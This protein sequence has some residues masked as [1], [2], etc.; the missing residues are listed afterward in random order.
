M[1]KKLILE[2]KCLGLKVVFFLWSEIQIHEFKRLGLGIEQGFL[3]WVAGDTM[4]MKLF[5][6][7]LTES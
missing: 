5:L 7:V 6:S 2:K 1:F 3:Y 4:E